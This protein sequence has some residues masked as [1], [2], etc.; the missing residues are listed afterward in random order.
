[1][2]TYT[3]K[4]SNNNNNNTKKFFTFSFLK[5]N[6]PTDYSKVLDDIILDNLMETNSYLK[7]YKTKQEDAKIFEASTASLKD[8]EFAEAASFLANYSKKNTFP[9]ILGKVYKLAGNIPVIFYDDEIQIDRDIYS[10]DDF[11]NL[12]FLNTLSAP[13]KKIIIDIYTNS[14]NINIEINK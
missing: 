8:N 5:K 2:N 11:E 7:D 6:K 1:M 4:T 13:K 14:H 9:F 10:Y 12:A 3:F